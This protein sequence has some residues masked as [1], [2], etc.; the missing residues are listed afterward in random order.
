M[1]K[2]LRAPPRPSPKSLLSEGVQVFSGAEKL[3]SGVVR[4][5]RQDH[6]RG[7]RLPPQGN[8]PSASY[9]LILFGA[10][11]SQRTREQRNK[12]SSSHRGFPH[13]RAPRHGRNFPQI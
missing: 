1:P 6:S 3:F 8:R 2:A 5:Y 4:L 7:R 9:P 12:G 10:A 11:K 13:R